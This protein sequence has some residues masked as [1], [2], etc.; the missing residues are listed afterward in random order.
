MTTTQIST[1]QFTR[2]FRIVRTRPLQV[3]DR[4]EVLGTWTP[5]P[6]KPVPVDFEER[7]RKDSAAAM[8]VSFAALLK[9]GKKR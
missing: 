5:A 1:R 9:E 3:T 8:P 4:G 7:A 6:S 2:E